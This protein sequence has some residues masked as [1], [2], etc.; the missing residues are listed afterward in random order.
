MSRTMRTW[1]S[2]MC[3][4]GPEVAEAAVTGGRR[5]RSHNGIWNLESGG[6]GRGEGEAT[7]A[8]RRKRNGSLDRLF[9][10]AWGVCLG[11]WGG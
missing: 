11:W 1:E 9:L 6:A 5:S 3:R 7:E 4:A 2:R 10:G 8:W